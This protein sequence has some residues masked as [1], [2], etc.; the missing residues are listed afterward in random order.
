MKNRIITGILLVV[1]ICA[2]AQ[3]RY[4]ADWASID[5]RPAATMLGNASSIKYSF[6]K[7]N[8]TIIPPVLHPGRLPCQSAWVFKLSGCLNGKN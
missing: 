6:E 3:T 8:I 7:N 2:S 1:S 5:C 4:R